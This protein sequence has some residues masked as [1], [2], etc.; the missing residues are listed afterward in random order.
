MPD[1][2]IAV[3]VLA[4]FYFAFRSIGLWR[5]VWLSIAG[6][7]GGWEL[8]SL[9]MTRLSISQAYWQ[10]AETSVWWWFPALLVALGG[11]GLAWHLVWKR[12]RRRR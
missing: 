12:I 8:Y 6:L 4:G 2:L 3:G 5:W 7:V 9:A 10:W 11:I 1:A